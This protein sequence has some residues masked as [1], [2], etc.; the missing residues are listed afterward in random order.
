MWTDEKGKAVW[1]WVTEVGFLIVSVLQLPPMSLTSVKDK[2]TVVQVEDNSVEAFEQDDTI[3]LRNKLISA[4]I[5]KR[6]GQLLSMTM[7]EL[8]SSLQVKTGMLLEEAYDFFDVVRP[9]HRGNRFILYDDIP[10]YW[11]AWDVMD[12]HLETGKPCET[13][14]DE[15]EIVEKTPIRVAVEFIVKIGENSQ[16]KQ[17]IVLRPDQPYLEFE[18]KI[19]WSERH[20]L[21]KVEFPINVRSGEATYEIQF[22]HIK[23]PSHRNTTWDSAKFEVSEGDYL[24]RGTG[25]VRVGFGEARCCGG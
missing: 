13:L 24:V 21:L 6:T 15:A 22:G 3:V 25:Q 17:K 10:L 8:V 4:T 19:D 9:G 23:R 2:A 14:E 7:F 18:S 16:L 5:H 1:N 11:D 12:Y 20:K